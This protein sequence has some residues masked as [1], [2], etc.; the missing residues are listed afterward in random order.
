MRAAVADSTPKPAI[1]RRTIKRRAAGTQ[2][3]T[4]TQ[5]G[6]TTRIKAADN[7]PR[8]PIMQAR[9]ADMRQR[10]VTTQERAP[11]IRR[12]ATVAMRE[13]DVQR[14]AVETM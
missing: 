1:R 4:I 11:D 10:V 2:Q 3:G 12:M 5:Q 9:P 13:R 7:T 8:I 14:A 6:T